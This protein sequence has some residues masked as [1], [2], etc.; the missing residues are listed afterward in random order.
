MR[1]ETL[2]VPKSS[3]VILE[4]GKVA[5]GPPNIGLSLPARK[6]DGTGHKGN[7]WIGQ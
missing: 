1:G 2:P 7:Y 4:K 6:K 3:R 5:L